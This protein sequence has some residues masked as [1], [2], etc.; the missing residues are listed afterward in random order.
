MVFRIFQKVKE[1]CGFGGLTLRLNFG[2]F[3]IKVLLWISFWVS[4]E[5]FGQGLEKLGL[6]IKLY[7]YFMMFIVSNCLQAI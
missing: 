3:L 6:F 1:F 7:L 4:A 2:G 5:V